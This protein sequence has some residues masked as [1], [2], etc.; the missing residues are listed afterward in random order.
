MSGQQSESLAPINIGAKKK[1]NDNE[2]DDDSN[3]S[4]RYESR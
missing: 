1:E 4:S 2:Y 3:T